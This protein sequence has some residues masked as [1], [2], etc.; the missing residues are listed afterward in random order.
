MYRSA[1]KKVTYSVD[2]GLNDSFIEAISVG[3]GGIMYKGLI[4][5]TIE[6]LMRTYI[7]EVRNEARMMQQ[8]QSAKQQQNSPIM[9]ARLRK[10]LDQI[11]TLLEDE[12]ELEYGEHNSI[13]QHHLIHGLM[14]VKGIHDKRTI[15]KWTEFFITYKILAK[16][17]VQMYSIVRESDEEVQAA[18]F[19]QNKNMLDAIS[20]GVMS[21]EDRAALENL[22]KRQKL[23]KKEKQRQAAARKIEA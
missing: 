12:G 5:E 8:A 15:R 17:G 23:Q 10:L 9:A 2:D 18:A 1:K 4:S 7:V 22:L 13:S 19:H 21:E 20:R 16:T 11:Q 14:N 6:H 3:N